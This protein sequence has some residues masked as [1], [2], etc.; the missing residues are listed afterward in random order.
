M[1]VKH[2][3]S[4]AAW[5]RREFR[6]D[7][8]QKAA[9]FETHRPGG[10]VLPRA[11]LAQIDL[12]G[13]WRKKFRNF[14]DFRNLADTNGAVGGAFRYATNRATGQT[15][16]STANTRRRGKI[17]G[18]LSIAG[19]HLR[20]SGT[21]RIDVRTRRDGEFFLVEIQR[22]MAVESAAERPAAHLYGALLHNQ[23]RLR[24]GTRLGDRPQNHGRMA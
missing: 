8:W 18:E 10:R 22:T 23:G 12:S 16:V 13:C 15:P 7:A 19:S 9:Y 3:P 4:P 5:P 6:A 2:C 17:V 24:Q 14:G 21:G 20:V 11:P 1:S